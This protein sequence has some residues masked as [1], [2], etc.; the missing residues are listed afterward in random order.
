MKYTAICTATLLALAACGESEPAS[1]LN[2]AAEVIPATNIIDEADA[3]EIGALESTSPRSQ[4]E[5]NADINLTAL[6]AY[7]DHA[8]QFKTETG[9]YPL[10]KRSFRSALGAFQD[11]AEAVA[12]EGEEVNLGLPDGAEMKQPGRI[13]YRSDGTDYKLIA[14]RTGDCSIVKERDPSLIDPKRDYG[15]GDCIAYGYWTSGAETW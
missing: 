6:S 15:P 2:D 3:A 13:V 5:T 4:A 8:E 14:Q 12:D 7:R 11:A 9:S 1:N 10:T